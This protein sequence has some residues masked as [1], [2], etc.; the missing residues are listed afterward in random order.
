[1]S[2]QPTDA[3]IAD[4]IIAAV[5]AGKPIPFKPKVFAEVVNDKTVSPPHYRREC[6]AA[7]GHGGNNGTRIY[8]PN[9]KYDM[10]TGET[11]KG[12]A[13]CEICGETDVA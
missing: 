8:Y 10:R 3:P 5:Q 11:D 2:E 9:P 12:L 13:V 4:Q 7:G 1:M 6:E